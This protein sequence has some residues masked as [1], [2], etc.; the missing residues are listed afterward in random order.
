MNLVKK[1]A[2]G[3]VEAIRLG[4]G[5]IGPPLISVFLYVVDGLVIDTGQHNMQKVV[6]ELLKAK[7]L[8]QILLTHHHEDHTGNAFALG[9]GHQIAVSAHPL[10]VEKVCCLRASLPV[11]GDS[12]AVISSVALFILSFR[13]FLFQ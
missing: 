6:V 13:I 11:V 10:T 2:F 1:T 4:F 12:I 8:D 3:E 7:K 9:K 5:P